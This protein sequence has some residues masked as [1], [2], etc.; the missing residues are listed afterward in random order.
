MDFN[1]SE[2]VVTREDVDTLIMDI[3]ILI[4]SLYRSGNGSYDQTIKN[5]VRSS[6]AKLLKTIGTSREE[7]QA[8]LEQL[9]SKLLSAKYLKL[10]I[11]FD[12]SVETINRIADW[13]RRNID[14]E[15]VLDLKIDRSI[16][17]GAIIE[18]EGRYID[19]SVNKQLNVALEKL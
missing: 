18:H 1:L 12:P 5:S 7:R 13:V 11:A 8:A 6:T 15:I 16:I 2:M 9:K 17:A 10:T 3:D 14:S 19:H 4:D